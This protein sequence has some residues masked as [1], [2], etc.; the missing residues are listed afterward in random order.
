MTQNLHCG[1]SVHAAILADLKAFRAM[2]LCGR[3]Y[4][5]VEAADEIDR[6]ILEMRNCACGS[7]LSISLGIG[8]RLVRAR[9]ARGGLGDQSM[10]GRCKRALGGDAEAV[11]SYLDAVEMEPMMGGGR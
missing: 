4:Q 6:D 1:T 7:T 8:E 11:R 9:A 3:G 10:I 5:I 2:P